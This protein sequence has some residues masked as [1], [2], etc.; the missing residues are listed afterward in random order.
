M[1]HSSNQLYGYDSN[2]SKRF[3]FTLCS[4]C[5]SQLTRDQKSYYKSEKNKDPT[6]ENNQILINEKSETTIIKFL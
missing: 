6:Q 1:S 4:K 2:F 3:D 5:N